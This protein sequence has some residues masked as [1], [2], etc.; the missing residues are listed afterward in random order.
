MAD[1]V[2]PRLLVLSSRVPYPVVGGDRLR[3][4]RLVALLSERFDVHLLALHEGPP[5]ADTGRALRAIASKVT[6]ISRTPWEHRWRALRSGILRNKPLQV[7]YYDFPDLHAVTAAAAREADAVF[8]FHVRMAEYARHLRLPRF[9]DLVDAISMNY[10]RALRN[11]LSPVWRFIYQYEV[12][13]LRRY[14]CET[15]GTFDRSFII[16]DVDR[17]YLVNA[18]AP[19]DRLTVLPN[20]T[21]YGSGPMPTPVRED[22]DFCF[23]GNMETQSNSAAA[24]YFAREVVAFLVR[25]GREIN[26]YI[27]GVRPRPE[28]RALHDGRRI[29][30]TGEVPQPAE[31]I[32][33]SRVVVAPM[34][35]GAGIQNKILEAMA[36]GKVVLTTTVGASGLEVSPGVHLAV[37]D[38]PEE[39][40][41]RAAELLDNAAVREMIGRQAQMRIEHRYRWPRIGEI[42]HREIEQVLDARS[43]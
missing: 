30:V 11:Q 1:R 9:V 7:G 15:I 29:F 37:A 33:R 39:M 40:R 31:Y 3:V 10:E 28:I 32:R 13:R 2:R 25:E 21:D 42:L 19:A 4:H 41:M 18:G 5:D 23:V 17:Q 22:I 14:E 20:G 6:L 36:L 26:Y 43:K 34:L 27:V 16:S 35:F 12:G 24:A 8:C 38:S